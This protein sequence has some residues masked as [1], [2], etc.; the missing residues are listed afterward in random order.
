M[1]WRN[2][3]TGT[4]YESA[5]FNGTGIVEV[6]TQN[7]SKFLVVEKNLEQVRPVETK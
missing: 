4:I 1:K 2:K 7:G 6:V 3:K 5:D